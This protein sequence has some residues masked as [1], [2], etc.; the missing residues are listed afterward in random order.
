MNEQT[1]QKEQTGTKVPDIQREAYKIWFANNIQVNRGMSFA[2][3]LELAES[4][5][6]V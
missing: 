2:T 5:V 4:G 1:E 6:R 3:A